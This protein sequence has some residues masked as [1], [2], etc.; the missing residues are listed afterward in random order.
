[1]KQYS[2]NFQI[3]LLSLYKHSLNIV[4]AH[5]KIKSNN[6]FLEQ[7]PE[8]SLIILYRCDNRLNIK[9]LHKRISET[10]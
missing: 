6:V 2:D 3:I 10:L 7:V 4:A 9:E 5:I 1:M 8:L